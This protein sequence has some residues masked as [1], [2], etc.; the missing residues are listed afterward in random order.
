MMSPADKL[1]SITP[2]LQNTSLE[3]NNSLSRS[4]SESFNQVANDNLTSE[5]PARSAGSGYDA[6]Y[7]LMLVPMREAMDILQETER[8]FQRRECALKDLVEDAL[9]AD[10]SNF[11]PV[12]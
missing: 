10:I 11:R 8:R 2:D 5:H 4:L 12:S 1:A 6:G 7:P 3:S 9:A